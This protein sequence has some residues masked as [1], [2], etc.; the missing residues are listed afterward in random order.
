MTIWFLAQ[1]I[2]QK[3]KRND[4]GNY[5]VR[6]TYIQ[7]NEPYYTR[8]D[9][10]DFVESLPADNGTDSEH[11][12]IGTGGINGNFENTPTT[13]TP[14]PI[15]AP[16]ELYDF[17]SLMVFGEYHFG[18]YITPEDIDHMINMYHAYWRD[19]KYQNNLLD[20]L[21]TSTESP[22]ELDRRIR[23]FEAKE[24]EKDI[25]TSKEYFQNAEDCF[26]R[27]GGIGENIS[28]LE[29][30]AIS[31]ENA[32]EC[33]TIEIPGEYSPFYQ[34][35]HSSIIRYSGVIGSGNAQY[36]GGKEYDI[37]YHMG[38]LLCKPALNLENITQP[39]RYYSLCS[40]Y[41]LLKDA[42]DH[43][44]L[45]STYAVEVAYYYLLVCS[46]IVNAME[47]EQSQEMENRVKLA[48]YQLWERVNEKP[49]NPTYISYYREAERVMEMLFQQY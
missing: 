21:N 47:P 43:S 33:E 40:S 37:K 3:I 12:P 44:S 45:D 19:K 34:Y 20:I 22:E 35:I 7:Q 15:I 6:T 27:Y 9:P 31:A 25:I 18:E 16:K 13:S 2:F 17:S 41:V 4:E 30:S 38:K 49:G 5:I 32:A 29:Y 23:E 1:V 39:E 28:F 26:Y 46:K 42:F 24:K 11:P 8:I 10:A 14:P 48:F 36:S